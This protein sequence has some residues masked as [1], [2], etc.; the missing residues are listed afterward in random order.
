[1][2]SYLQHRTLFAPHIRKRPV[3]NLGIIVVIPAYDE[4][5]LL[6]SLMNLKKCDLPPCGVEVI[7]VVNDSEKDSAEVRERN[8]TTANQVRAWANSNSSPRLRFFV[9]YRS[10]LPKKH[11]GVGLARK[12]GMDEACWRFEKMGNPRGI[13]A[14]FDADSKCQ[15]NYLVE[16]HRHFQEHPKTSAC[17][18]HF[19]H[20][21][22][23]AEFE[24]EVYEAITQYELH[25]RYYIDA[26]RFA[27]FP[28][29][30]QT[31]GSSMAVRC[32]DYQ[33]QGGMNKRQ[34]G[35]DFYFLHKFIGLGN[36]TELHTTA[37]LPSP[38]PSHRVPFGT[39]RAVG[40]L[41]RQKAIAYDTYAP[42]SFV[43]LR[44]FL[45]DVGRFRQPTYSEQMEGEAL[46]AFLPTVDFE[47]RTEEIRSNT[48]N[49]AAFEKRF[50]QWF[51]AFQLMKYL[52]FARDHF[53]PDVPIV[54]AASW[55]LEQGGRP[56]PEKVTP[57]T[58]LK[59]YRTWDQT[60]AS[61]SL[62]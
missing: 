22:E 40:Q 35:E 47:A 51:N 61:W 20:P 2:T 24:E 55:L 46:A 19:E 50:F 11:A 27:K 62:M 29:A 16:L 45:G 39:G 6:L 3:I 49:A 57:K 34:A 59:M 8:Q 28:L 56:L 4:P 58:L 60:H 26:Q 43:E 23:G 7:I 9:I 12:I 44:G 21:L 13:I 37:V 54:E 36:F 48:S 18:I 42:Q 25:L 17:S 10:E 30:Y 31:I 5:F 32:R 53:Y 38:R 14:C 15:P 33:Q 41:T 52:H 1:M